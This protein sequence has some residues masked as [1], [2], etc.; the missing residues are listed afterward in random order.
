MPKK[1]ICVGIVAYDG[2]DGQV[3]QDYM[4]LMYHL[5]KYHS[6]EYNFQLAIKWKSEQFRARNAIVKAALQYRADYIWMLDDDHIIHVENLVNPHFGRMDDYDL[7]IKLVKRLEEHPDAGVVGALYYQRGGDYYPVI[8]Q[9]P[10]DDPR[11]FFLTH[12]EISRRM[13]KVDVTGG[14]CM[15]IRTSI[16]DKIKEPW[17]KPEHEFGTD[18]QLCKQAREAGF[19]VWCDTSLEIG[20][21]QKEKRVI[22]SELISKETREVLTGYKPLIRFRKDVEEYLGMSMEQVADLSMD[23]DFNRAND[24]AREDLV[25]YYASL[26]NEQLARQ[27][28]YHSSN[29][30]IEEMKFFHSTIRTDIGAYG[31]DYGCGAAPVGFEFA[32]QG[33]KMDFIDIDGA[34]GYEF[35]KWRAKKHSIDCGWKLKGPYDYV[36]M[37]DSIEHIVDWEG[38][39]SKVIDAIR[40]GGVLAT[41][42][43]RNQDFDNP[44]HVSMDH[45]AV[46]E[47]LFSRG[48][49]SESGLF[50]VKEAEEE[51]AA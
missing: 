35:L 15:M 13:Q 24:Y 36:L 31:C 17:F 1:T 49:N 30:V 26:G 34:G 14:G 5:G 48:M 16:F 45:A 7:P 32:L 3:A 25:S 9:E 2:L 23:Y 21:M 42:Y 46:R 40:P 47:F 39:L 29:P 37:L 20:H 12:A 27:Y 4:R 38:V 10:K 50:W 22:T 43:F 18:I 8:L 28:L 41:N 6:D 33:N 19:E 11:P 44:E 51:E